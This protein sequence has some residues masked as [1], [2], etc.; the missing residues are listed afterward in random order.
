M[1]Q[2]AGGAQNQNN[3]II[4]ILKKFLCVNPVCNFFND[5]FQCS[6]RDHLLIDEQWSDDQ[7]RFTYFLSKPSSM[8]CAFFS[9]EIGSQD[10]KFGVKVVSPRRGA[11]LVP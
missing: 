8:L 9:F 2:C 6:V 11:C 7:K 3:Q 10:E 4:F 1:Q 5:T